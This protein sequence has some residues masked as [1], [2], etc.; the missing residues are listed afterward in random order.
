[1]F[2]DG[3]YFN[4]ASKQL[5]ENWQLMKVGKLNVPT[6]DEWVADISQ[7]GQVIGVDPSVITVGT[8]V[9]EKA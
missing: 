5:D 2:T 1:L 3:R 4:Q 6:W 8:S 9:H 7:E